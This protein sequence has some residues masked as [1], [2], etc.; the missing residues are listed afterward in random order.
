MAEAE[1]LYNAM[2]E[3]AKALPYY[4]TAWPPK[5][6]RRMQP[7]G[8]LPHRIELMGG[9]ASTIGRHAAGAAPLADARLEA[10]LRGWLALKASEGSDTERPLYES[11]DV[12]ELVQRLL[13][14]RP[15]VFFKSH[16]E[17]ALRTGETGAGG[18]ALDLENGTLGGFALVGTDAEEAPLTLANTLSYDE[19]ALSA[20]LSVANPTVFI[21]N[22]D[23]GNQATPGRP[24][25]FEPEGVYTGAVGA[26]FEA[27]EQMEWR[28]MVVTFEQNTVAKGYGAQAD[29]AATQTK[30]LKLWADFYEVGSFSSFDEVEA[31][32]EAAA[33]TL[34][35]ECRYVPLSIVRH[36]NISKAKYF[37]KMVYKKRLAAVLAP[38]LLDSNRRAADAGTT[39]FCVTTGLGLGAWGIDKCQRLLMREV[40]AELLTNLPLPSV[41]DFVGATPQELGATNGEWLG[42]N[43]GSSSAGTNPTPRTLSLRITRLTPGAAPVRIQPAKSGG[44]AWRSPATKL[45]G[46]DQGKLLCAMYAWDGGAYPGNEFYEPYGSEPAFFSTPPCKIYRALIHTMYLTRRETPLQC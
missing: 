7:V 33:E 14:Q 36:G 23:R 43:N 9:H 38:W 2:L 26:R 1:D 37:D 46:A 3:R 39:A 27:C 22:G 25:S 40:Y 21:N 30:L 13:V 35:G 24:G 32:V 11:M 17:Y 20:L 8:L 34:G 19:M 5:R 4:E 31:E 10:L 16:D 29:P 6:D 42:T 12:V 41:S 44:G 18:A 15:L 28:H 45:S